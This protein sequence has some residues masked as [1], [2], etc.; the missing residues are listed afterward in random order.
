MNTK[1]LT[2][3]AGAALLAMS[4][5]SV[6]AVPVLGL[7]DYGFNIDGVVSMPSLGDP[8][9]GEVSLASFDDFTG[10]GSINVTITGAGAHTFDA[11]F[12]HEI[13]EALNTF[14]NESGAATGGAAAGQSW[15]IDEPGFINGDIFMNFQDSLLDN[16]IGTSIWGDT[17]FP[18]DVS[19]AMGWDFN[20]LAGETAIITLLLSDL[21][22]GGGFFLTHSDADSQ[23]EFYLSS[24]LTIRGGGVPTPEPSI[25]LLLGVGL[26]GM[27]V[28]RRRKKA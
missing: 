1:R 18:D 17:I 28:N 26:A 21:D 10:L 4:S 15:E 6:Q 19:M 11:F 8:V 24:T 5:L 20:L 13:D 22:N 3:W 16:G 23:Y 7:Y 2:L 14:F 12:D 9:P 27:V 25:L